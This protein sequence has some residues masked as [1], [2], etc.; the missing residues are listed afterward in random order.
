M[1]RMLP[2]PAPLVNALRAAVTQQD[3]LR[4]SGF[5]Q[6]FDGSGYLENVK[7]PV[8]LFDMLREEMTAQ[9]TRDVA[10]ALSD[11]RD[12]ATFRGASRS[13]SCVS[14]QDRGP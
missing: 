9:T 5:S 8:L 11:G 13:M 4:L 1:E 10:A 2:S 14:S 7:C 12:N 3:F 6:T